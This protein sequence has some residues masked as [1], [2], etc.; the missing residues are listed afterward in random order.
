MGRSVPPLA[1]VVVSACLAFA[2]SRGRAAGFEVG[3]HTA[4]STARGGTGVASKEDPS[5]LYFNPS[6]LPAAEGLQFQLGGELIDTNVTF[7]RDDLVIGEGDDAQRTTFDTARNETP[8]T[9]VPSLALSYDFG[10]DNF[11][12]AIGVFTPHSVSEKCYGELAN[13]NCEVDRDGGARHMLVEADIVEF[14]GMA[15]AGYEFDLAEGSLR[16][17]ASA[18]IARQ[19]ADF[20]IVV[21]SEIN[22]SSPYEEDPEDEAVFDAEELTD[23]N[24]IGVF[25]A[26]YQHKNHRVALSYRPPIKW[27]SDGKASIDFPDNLEGFGPELTDD[28]I[29]FETWQAGSLRVGWQYRRGTHPGPSG[30]PKWDVEVNAIWEDWS[31]V[32]NF[33]LDPAGDVGSSMTDSDEPIVELRPFFQRK[34]WQDTFSLRLGGSWGAASWVTLHGG[35]FVES[36][37]QREAFTNVDFPSWFRV[38]GSVGASFHPTDWVD[39]DVAFMHVASPGG[40]SVANGE[41]FNKIPTSDCA[42]P[43]F[44]DDACPAPGQPPGNPQNN[45]EWSTHYNIGSLGATFRF[46]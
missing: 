5:A 39:L 8:V 11:G 19:S 23:T 29:T 4:K 14:Y 17:G 42:G 24:L 20:K 30:R 16:L 33:K 7:D 45:G 27:E 3:E 44:D 22:P 36:A 6:L 40:R 21:N 26:T 32:E 25:G 46:N 2:P 18:L 37:A 31:R 15:G 28:A 41:V 13:G 38:A 35:S 1:L 34:N 12:A 43:D 9:P 10:I